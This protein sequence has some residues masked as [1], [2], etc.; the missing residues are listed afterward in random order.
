[1]KKKI[2]ISYRITGEDREELKTT[3][4]RI[5]QSI[6]TVG[7]DCFYSFQKDDFFQENNFTKK[8]ILEYAPKEIDKADCV[9]VVVKSQEKSEGMLLEIGYALAKNKKIVLA[10]KKDIQTVF[11]CEMAS[12]IIEFENLDDLNARLSV[13]S[14]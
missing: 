12:S 3:M 5:C 11:L 9:L 2:F 13:L 7:F 6:E 14:F 10:I 8:Q 4:Q 1:M